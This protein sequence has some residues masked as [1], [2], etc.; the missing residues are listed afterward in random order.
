MSVD[1]SKLE[2][3][4]SVKFRNGKVGFIGLIQESNYSGVGDGFAVHFFSENFSGNPCYFRDNYFIGG[5]VMLG[6]DA[7]CN[8]VEII[9]SPK[10]K[11]DDMKTAYVQGLLQPDNHLDDDEWLEQ[12]KENRNG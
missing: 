12:Y 11:D 8:I 3:G 10:W 9:K 6:G 4:D 7:S 1:L 5:G 2:A